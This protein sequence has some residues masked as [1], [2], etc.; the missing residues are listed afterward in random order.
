MYKPGCHEAQEWLSTKASGALSEAEKIRLNDHLDRCADCAA[1]AAQHQYWIELLRGRT[2]ALS[3]E[4]LSSMAHRIGT[5]KIEPKTL[6]PLTP[7][8]WIG[9]AVALAASLVA[10][11]FVSRFFR[12]EEMVNAVGIK[13][14]KGPHQGMIQ[15]INGAQVELLP[16]EGGNVRVYLSDA[17]GTPHR[18]TGN[19][20]MTVSS[21]AFSP[22]EVTLT[23]AEDGA[24]LVG[25]LPRIPEAPVELK[26]GFP[27]GVV[28]VFPSVPFAPLTTTVSVAPPISVATPGRAVAKLGDHSAEVTISP[29][30]EVRVQVFDSGAKALPTS[31]LSIPV[32]ELEHQKTRYQVKLK[33]HPTE[34]YLVGMLNAKL[35]IPERTELLVWCPKSILIEGVV[36]E[37]SVIVFSTYIVNVSIL[38]TPTVIIKKHKHKGSHKGSHKSSHR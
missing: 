9:A 29:K 21:E 2:A 1:W 19:I 6:R 3:P 36:F 16:L 20:P 24:Y 31:N 27:S 25:R 14:G 23:P 18:A 28:F 4:K 37:P 15:E 17:N 32:V 13:S 38:V 10:V 11:F 7:R 35:S 5:A 30:G 34:P 12:P 22:T 33:P 8:H 26:L